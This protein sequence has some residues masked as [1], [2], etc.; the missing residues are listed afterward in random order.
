MPTYD[1]RCPKCGN[2]FE[3]FQQITA[4]PNANCPVCG[5]PSK[6]MISTGI[7]VIFKGTGF[8]QT[9]Y[10]QKDEKTKREGKKKDSKPSTE[11]KP[12]AKADKKE[13][14]PK[15]EKTKE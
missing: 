3:A 11:S 10:K 9:D 2:E 4:P 15:T 13:A 12:E 8:Y 7:G 5:E 14:A 6:R 1:Y